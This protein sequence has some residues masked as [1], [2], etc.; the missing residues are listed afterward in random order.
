MLGLFVV[1]IPQHLHEPLDYRGV[2]PFQRLDR[3]L[4]KVIAQH[5]FRVGA[6][7]ALVARIRR[8]RPQAIPSPLP[9][10]AIQTRLD[11]IEVP[12]ELLT[13][14]EHYALEVK[15]DSMIDAGILDGDTIILRKT[16][17]ASNG[18][19]VVALV[20]EQEA[21]LQR[22]GVRRQPTGAVVEI[23]VGGRVLFSTPRNF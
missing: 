9:I 22:L 5:I 8:L 14:G 19:I 16:E 17:D 1:R 2:V 18:D 11:T 10:E 12:P 13:K 20:D 6:P 7:H 15:G 4:R 21:T 3:L 23:K